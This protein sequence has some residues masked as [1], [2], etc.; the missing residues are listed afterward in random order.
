M[1]IH[2]YDIGDVVRIYSIFTEDPVVPTDDPVPIDPATVSLTILKP[3]GTS[4]SYTYAGSTVA[5]DST[6]NYH[7][8]F[9]P[10][11]RGTYKYR[12]ASTGT[13]ASAKEGK[14]QVRVQEVT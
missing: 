5:K 8:D 9:A 10:T 2:T 1:A 6:G 4:Q 3:D 14:F 12:W 11:A 13:G 7:V